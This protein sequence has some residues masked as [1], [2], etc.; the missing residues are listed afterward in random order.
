M[1]HFSLSP[2]VYCDCVKI[3][4][5]ITA[6]VAV[7]VAIAIAVVLILLFHFL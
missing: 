1:R 3:A 7:A 5:V 6:A 4:A 2:P